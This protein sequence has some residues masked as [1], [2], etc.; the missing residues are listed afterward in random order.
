M[1]MPPR[2]SSSGM[3]GIRR[4][5]QRRRPKPLAPRRSAA[6]K[7][8]PPPLEGSRYQG[9]SNRPEPVRLPR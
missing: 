1:V 9:F 6:S 7:P 8:S 2:S 3:Q 5:L 4:E